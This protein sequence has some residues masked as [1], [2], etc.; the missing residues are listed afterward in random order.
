[1]VQDPGD[2]DDEHQAAEKFSEAVLRSIVEHLHKRHQM[3]EQDLVLLHL[4]GVTMSELRMEHHVDEKEYQLY[5][6]NT[7]LRIYL[8]T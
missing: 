3:I 4:A 2:E 5:L 6:G 8:E 7:L 1:V